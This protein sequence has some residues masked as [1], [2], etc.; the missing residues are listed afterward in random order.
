MTLTTRTGDGLRS[1]RKFMCLSQGRC[2]YL[3]GI[4]I[5]T[6]SKLE[7]SD[8]PA[9]KYQVRMLELFEKHLA[10]NPELRKALKPVGD[11]PTFAGVAV[12]PAAPIAD[13]AAAEFKSMFGTDEK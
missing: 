11:A 4:S 7:N 10:A 1:M 13:D 9:W 2:S 5:P 12:P 8:K 6:L 3:L